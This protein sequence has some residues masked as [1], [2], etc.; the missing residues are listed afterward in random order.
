M[1]SS[2]LTAELGLSFCVKDN[3]TFALPN[4]GLAADT[5]PFLR[6]LFLCR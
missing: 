6:S 3:L 5:E 2:T 1:G 4:V